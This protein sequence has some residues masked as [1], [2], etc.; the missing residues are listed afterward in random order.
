MLDLDA[1]L[2]KYDVAGSIILLAGSRKVAPDDREKLRN[3]GRLLAKRSKELIFRSGNANGSDTF[4]VEGVGDVDRSRVE[5][6]LPYPTHQPQNRVGY[7]SLSIDQVD[8]LN[9]PTLL[10]QAKM[11]SG[12][13]YGIEQYLGGQTNGD[14]IATAKLILR[15]TLM[16]TGAEKVKPAN[17]AIFYVDKTTTKPGGTG[18][19]I[20]VCEQMHVDYL[21]QDTWFSWL[22]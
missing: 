12:A 4:F 11:H 16:V 18:H 1:F 13:R 7:D 3:L 2:E 15:S 21:D 10:E 5:I 6:I 19:T 20:R 14:K 9:E 22:D 17:F 8:V